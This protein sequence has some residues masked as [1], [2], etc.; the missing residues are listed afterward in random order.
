LA[1]GGGG[2]RPPAPPP[3]SRRR[4]WRFAHHAGARPPGQDATA[5]HPDLRIE[6]GIGV[7]H[8]PCGDSASITLKAQTPLAKLVGI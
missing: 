5:Q 3:R 8:K 7:G 4:G 2:L 6:R 1:E